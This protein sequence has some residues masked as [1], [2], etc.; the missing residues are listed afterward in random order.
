[1]SL[2]YTVHRW[3]SGRMLACHA[4]GPGSIPGRCKFCFGPTNPGKHENKKSFGGAGYRSRYLSHAKRALYHLSY[5]PS[6]ASC[7]DI[8]K[9]VPGRQ[10][11]KQVFK[12][13]L[14]SLN[15]NDD[16]CKLTFCHLTFDSSVGRAVD[17]S[18]TLSDIHRSLVQIRL[19]GFF[20]TSTQLF[21]TDRTDVSECR[22]FVF[23]GKSRHLL[24]NQEAR[25]AQSVE[26]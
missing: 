26:R 11:S 12:D 19:E 5:A 7:P 22:H 13:K 1:M 25:V 9:S 21:I 4:G 15:Q 8:V 16:L 24:Y 14:R 2:L 23:R 17:C 10:Q 18:R 6:M 20:F 3:F